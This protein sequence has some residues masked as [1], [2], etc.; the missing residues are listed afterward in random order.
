MKKSILWLFC[1]IIYLG[2]CTSSAKL[3][4]HPNVTI[5]TQGL[6]DIRVTYNGSPTVPANVGSYKVGVFSYYESPEL[7]AAKMH[8]KVVVVLSIS[9]L[10][11]CIVS[12]IHEKLKEKEIKLPDEFTQNY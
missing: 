6:K 7:M 2:S 11:L 10:I 9:F 5:S 4:K 1:I 12:F 3:E 8:L